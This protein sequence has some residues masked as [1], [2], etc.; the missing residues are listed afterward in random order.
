MTVGTAITAFEARLPG[1][2]LMRDVA[3]HI[4]DYA[5][6]NGRNR[7]VTKEILEVSTFAEDGPTL[8]WLGAELNAQ[9]ALVAS[10]ALF[11]AIQQAASSFTSA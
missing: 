4:D 10:E 2:K 11:Q 3:E 8:R 9:Q 6:D 1:L 5:L 7:A